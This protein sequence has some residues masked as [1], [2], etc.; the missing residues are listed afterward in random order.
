MPGI[1]HVGEFR[2]LVLRNAR[3]HSVDPHDDD[4]LKPGSIDHLLSVILPPRKT[5]VAMQF[6]AF[7]TRDTLKTESGA[8]SC[9]SLPIAIADL[10]FPS[11]P[12]GEKKKKN[13]PT[14]NCPGPPLRTRA[15]TSHGLFFPPEVWS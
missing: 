4:C 8:P 5:I 13:P 10:L 15:N 1:S 12:V 7:L 11:E 9:T 3:L 6:K 14:E 2:F